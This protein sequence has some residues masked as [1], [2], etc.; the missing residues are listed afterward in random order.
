M[1]FAFRAKLS[2]AEGPCNNPIGTMTKWGVVTAC[3]VRYLTR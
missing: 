3:A 1:E 2:S